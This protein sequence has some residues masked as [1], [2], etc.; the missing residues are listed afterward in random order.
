M[1]YALTLRGED[2]LLPPSVISSAVVGPM[3]SA[4]LPRYIPAHEFLAVVLA[5]SCH[6]HV[7]HVCCDELEWPVCAQAQG[8]WCRLVLHSYIAFGTISFSWLNVPYVLTANSL[9]TDGLRE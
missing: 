1:R 7:C 2:H 5:P 6:R 8:L 9:I 3:S 4:P